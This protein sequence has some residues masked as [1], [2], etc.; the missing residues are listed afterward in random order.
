MIWFWSVR[1]NSSPRDNAVP[2]SPKERQKKE[3]FEFYPNSF[4]KVRALIVGQ[5]PLSQ[6][7]NPSNKSDTRL[8]PTPRNNSREIDQLLTTSHLLLQY[9]PWTTGTPLPISQPICDLFGGKCTERGAGGQRRAVAERSVSISPHG[10]FILVGPPA[11]FL[12]KKVFQS[13][14]IPKKMTALPEYP[15]HFGTSP[16]LRLRS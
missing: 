15:R 14:G 12:L 6:R 7:K 13:L 11:L 2:K 4:Y 9:P 8:L 10:N 5:N 16:H 3:P 1:C